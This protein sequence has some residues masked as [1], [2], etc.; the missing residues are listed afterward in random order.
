M[1]KKRTRSGEGRWASGE[2]SQGTGISGFASSPPGVVE[3]EPEPE[4]EGSDAEE[5]GESF[6]AE[7]AIPEKA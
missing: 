5:E 2:V 3:E 1:E 6:E 7:K 4:P